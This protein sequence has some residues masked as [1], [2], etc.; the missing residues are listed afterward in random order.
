MVISGGF[1][2]F[3]SEIERAILQGRDVQDCAVVG[4]PDDK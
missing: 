2:I 4:V 1:N 3:P